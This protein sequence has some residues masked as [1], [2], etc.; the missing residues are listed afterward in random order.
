MEVLSAAYG[1]AYDDHDRVLR[2]QGASNRLLG[3][4]L[5]NAARAFIP[6][7]IGGSVGKMMTD[8]KSGA[9]FGD[10]VKDLVKAGLRGG[11]NALV[12]G[13]SAMKPASDD[14]RTW[15]AQAAVRVNDEKEYVLDLL[16]KWT[17][18]ANAKD[19]SLAL[20]RNGG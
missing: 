11:G 15:R 3:D 7:G 12:G 4:I 8:A 20:S 6:G 17:T 14:P 19:P 18:K 16:D 9:F 1:N 2:K 13:P 10:A 5:L